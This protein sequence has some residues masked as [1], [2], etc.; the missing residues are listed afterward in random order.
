MK[1]KI[2]GFTLIELLVVISIIAVLLAI[3]VFGI[4]N[5]R[6]S[7]RDGKRKTD[8]EQ[9]RSALE[10]YKADK[11]KYPSTSG[12]MNASSLS[13]SGYIA[14]IPSDP[15]PGRNYTYR[16][17]SISSGNCLA[18]KLCASLESVT[19]AVSGCGYSCGNGKTCS[20]EVIN[21]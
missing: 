11:S 19:T 7:S 3:S 18:Y 16:C 1:A 10:M 17:T 21:P 15:L 12:G 8:L 4:Q 20:Y 6:K 13:L 14:A 9:I 2:K 5:A